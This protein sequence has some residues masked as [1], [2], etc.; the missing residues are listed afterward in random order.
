MKIH[1]LNFAFGAAITAASVWLICSLFVWMAPGGMASLTTNMMHM[2]MTRT[3]WTI[4]LVGVIWGLVGWSL[5]AGISAWIL[6]TIYNLVTR[7]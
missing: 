3:G 4:S 2:D 6:A 1:A 5:F 7:H